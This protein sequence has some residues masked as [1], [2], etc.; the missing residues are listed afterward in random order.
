VSVSVRHTE[1][2]Q[3]DLLLHSI[4]DQDIIEVRARNERN[5]AKDTTDFFYSFGQYDRQT[6]SLF[7]DHGTYHYGSLYDIEKFG[8]GDHMV[9]SSALTLNQVDSPTLPSKNLSATENFLVDHTQTLQSLYDYN[10]NAFSSGPVDSFSHYGRAA[11]RHQLF[12]SLTSIVDVHGDTVDTESSSGSQ[13]LWRYGVGL[14]ETYTKRLSS[15]G[16]LTIGNNVRL[17]REQRENSGSLLDVVGERQTLNDAATTFLRQPRVISV[18]RVTDPNGIT[19]YVRGVDYELIRHGE[20]TEIRRLLTSTELLNG[21]TVLVDY[22]ASAQPSGSF[23]T[24]ADQFQIRLDLFKGLLGIYSRLN[25]IE[26]TD[27]ARF[28]LEDGFN[29]QSGVE[30]SWRWLRAGTE[31]ETRDSNLLTYNAINVYESAAFVPSDGATW[32]LDFR[33]RW[34][35][36]PTEHR[37]L[38]DYN[39]VTRY[40][41]RITSYLYYLVEGGVRWEQGQGLDQRQATARTE[42]NF[43]LG[44][45]RVHLGY[46]FNNDDIRGE[47]REKH[48]VYLRARRNF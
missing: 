13:T 37:S 9:L 18:T 8:Q 26:N 38:T 17:D 14:S 10:F 32:S 29:T 4:Y 30:A 33:Q 46:Q 31:Y 44:K 23:S 12:D 6:S 39:F 36:F 40:H 47:L 27:S 35:T 3:S 48:F 19:N 24:L 7:R 15:W 45:L 11:L 28:V 21:M 42:L 34:A 43:A 5:S 22:V 1:E 25:W 16:R 2:D 41:Q 20:L